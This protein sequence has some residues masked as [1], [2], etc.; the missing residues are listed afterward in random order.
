[1]DF[2]PNPHFGMQLRRQRSMRAALRRAGNEVAKHAT[3]F[4]RAA[5]APWMERAGA[6]RTIVVVEHDDRVQV[7]NTDHGGHL[8]EWGSKH[9]QPHAPLRRAVNAAGLHFDEQR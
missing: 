3:Q 4:A 2:Q 5:G 9:N 7:V 6:E 8:Q 1:M